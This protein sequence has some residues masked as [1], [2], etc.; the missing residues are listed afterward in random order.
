[1]G[2]SVGF[3]EGLGAEGGAG[4]GGMCSPSGNRAGGTWADSLFFRRAGRAVALVPPAL[5][6]NHHLVI[7]VTVDPEGIDAEDDEAEVLLFGRVAQ[8]DAD[9][10]TARPVPRRFP[11]DG[12][13]FH[14]LPGTTARVHQDDL[15]VVE[16]GDPARWS[17]FCQEQGASRAFRAASA[18]GVKRAS[19]AVRF[20][21]A[22]T[23]AVPYTTKATNPGP[24][25][26]KPSRPLRGV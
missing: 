2:E 23:S 14:R 11:Q 6:S 15:R 16:A 9:G 26:S 18:E 3:S 22:G 19:L 12:V 10:E 21:P 1:M 4:A 24:A 7:L 8:T 25:R 5:P 17:P 20:H 13:P